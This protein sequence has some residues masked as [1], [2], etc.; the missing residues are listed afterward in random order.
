MAQTRRVRPPLTVT[1]A[2]WKAL[3]LREAVFRVSQDRISWVWLVVE[4]LSHVLIMVWIFAVFRQRV[5]GGADSAVWIMVGILCF[6]VPRNVM[7]RGMDAIDSSEAL[8]TFRQVKPV[9]TVLVRAALEGML[10]SLI[11]LAIF[12][13]AGLFGVPVWP[14]DPLMALAAL[15][16]RWLFGLG[17][18]LTFSVLGNLV[19]EFGRLVRLLIQPVYIMSGVIF[20]LALVPAKLRDV[21]MLNPIVHG[22]ETARLAFMPGY[23]TVPGIDL[24]YLV[25][26]AVPLVFIGFVLHMR[27]RADLV[28]R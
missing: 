10:E 16:S 17:L 20:P 4:P 28:T 21:L 18:G 3:F 13:G 6:F 7:T 23:Q 1:F 25:Q 2:V 27:Y 26:C 12:T 24:W 19:A 5:I 11:F 8:Y 14:A 15:A 9:D 22:I